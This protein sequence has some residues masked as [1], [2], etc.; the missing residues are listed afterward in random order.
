M[1]LFIKD[2]ASGEYDPGNSNTSHVL[3]YQ[4]M[5]VYLDNGVVY[6]NTSHVL[7]YQICN[8]SFRFYHLYSNTSHVLIYQYN[9]LS[10]ICTSDGFKYI[11]CSYLSQPEKQPKK[12]ELAFKYI[13]CSYLSQPGENWMWSVRNIQ[14]HL[15]FLF[16]VFF[17]KRFYWKKNSNTS[18]VLIYQ[19]NS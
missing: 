19:H 8:I 17:F 10:F 1:F 3:I 7:I 9:A 15:M 13:S 18:H 14:I 5:P 6:S 11:S 12:H 2:W 4:Y 16:I